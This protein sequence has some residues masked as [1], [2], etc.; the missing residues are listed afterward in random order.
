MYRRRHARIAGCDG[1][2]DPRHSDLQQGGN[3]RRRDPRDRLDIVAAE[4][5][6]ACE[7]DG[8]VEKVAD[9][10]EVVVPVE[11]DV[12]RRQTARLAL[13]KPNGAD[14]DFMVSLFSRFELVAHRPHPVPDSPE[15]SEQRLLRDMQ[16]WQSH[17]FGRWAIEHNRQLI[18]FGGLTHMHGFE[19][20]NISYHLHPESWGKGYASEL[21]AETVAVGFGPL[22]AR[23]M[24]GLVRAANPASRRVLERNGFF[25]ER[26]VELHGAPTQLL[27][28]NAPPHKSC[29]PCEISTATDSGSA[30]YPLESGP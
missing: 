10:R 14:R 1:A 11:N 2:S 26:D 19:G 12:D 6:K 27:A 21:V 29:R 24:I 9:N 8:H 7:S 3:D 16:H 17:G 25:F 13:R 4:W 15:V 5:P 28:L 30:R 23:R 18:G 22:Q 20:L